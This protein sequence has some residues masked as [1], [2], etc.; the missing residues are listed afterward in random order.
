VEKAP[1]VLRGGTQSNIL[2]PIAKSMFMNLPMILASREQVLPM[3][4]QHIF[5]Q[6]KP[7]PAKV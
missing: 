5:I 2:L 4:R 1:P 7:L 3:L 6:G